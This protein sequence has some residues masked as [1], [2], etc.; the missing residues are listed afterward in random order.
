L[1]D[2]LDTY[3]FDWPLALEAEPLAELFQECIRRE[4]FADRLLPILMNDRAS[5]VPKLNLKVATLG[6]FRVTLNG[7]GVST[8]PR[9]QEL[10]VYLLLYAPCRADEVADAIWPRLSHDAA[11]NNLKVQICHLRA[12]G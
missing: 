12:Q 3:S 5:E 9:M 8:S 7:A 11:R 10:L 2:H 6:G 1:F 4:W